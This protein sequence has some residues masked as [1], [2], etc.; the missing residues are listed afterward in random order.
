MGGLKAGKRLC[1]IRYRCDKKKLPKTTAKAD[2]KIA[3]NSKKVSMQRWG[4][5]ADGWM[6]IIKLEV[7]LGW[8]GG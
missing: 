8:F 4:C 2:K 7:R 6:C 3:E 5:V 1:Q